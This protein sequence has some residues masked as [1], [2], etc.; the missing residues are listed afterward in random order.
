MLHDVLSVLPNIISA[1]ALA[2]AGIWAYFRVRVERSHTPH[3][4]LDIDCNLH[5]PEG[6]HYVSEVIILVNNKGLVRQDFR[7]MKL[8]I[9]AIVEGAELQL[10]EIYG[11]KRLDAPEKLLEVEV[12]KKTQT[13][14][15]L[16]VEPGVK[17][18]ITYSTKLPVT[19]ERTQKKIKY[20]LLRCKFFYK[21]KISHSVER[22]YSVEQC[23]NKPKKLYG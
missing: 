4:E 19:H 12:I 22:L 14:D 23:L 21:N 2:S 8:K 6:G 3:I 17:H 15:Y 10:K 9:R 11:E 20:L 13:E 16:F 5:G 18:M 1:L 7:S